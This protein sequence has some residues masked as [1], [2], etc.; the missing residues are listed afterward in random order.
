MNRNNVGPGIFYCVCVVVTIGCG[1]ADRR[2][3]VTGSVALDGKTLSRAIINFRPVP[4]NPSSSA[5]A[6]LEDGNFKISANQGLFP[7]DYNVIIQAFEETGRMVVDPQFGKVPETALVRF[8]EEKTL[9][10]TVSEESENRFDF[11][12]TR[13]RSAR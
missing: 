2:L 7:G 1:Q 8:Q 4:G 13:A 12:I 3:A 9:Q 6:G 10:V 11:Q 5:G